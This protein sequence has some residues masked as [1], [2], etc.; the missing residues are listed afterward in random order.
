MAHRQL[1]NAFQVYKRRNSNAILRPEK[2][3]MEKKKFLLLLLLL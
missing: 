2:I 3:E 1:R